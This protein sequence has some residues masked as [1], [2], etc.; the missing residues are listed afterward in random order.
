MQKKNLFSIIIILC[1]SVAFAQKDGDHKRRF[2]LNYFLKNFYDISS[3]PEY[4][5]NTYNAEVSTY[6]RKGGNDDGFNGTYSFIRRNADSSLVI[7][8]QQGPG[9]ITRFWTPTPTDDTLDFYIDD[10]TKPTFSIKYR[11][12]FTGK[13]YPFVAPLCANQLGGF[14]CYLPILFNKS[15]KI[16]ARAK[17]LRFHQIGYKLYPKDYFFKSFSINLDDAEK[18]TLAQIK[19]IWSKTNL[20]AKDV[21]QSNIGIKEVKKVTTIQPGQ[22]VTLFQSSMPGRITGFEFATQSQLDTLA[23]D[24]DI[25][26]TW[27]GENAP[28][29][30][31]PIADY[32][33][34]AFGTASMNGLLVGSDGKRHYSLF[35]MPY[36]KSAKVE[37]IYRK[38]NRAGDLSAV[39]LISKFYVENRKRNPLIEGKF[40]AVW[41]HLNPVPNGQPYP[42]IDIK[43]KG[44]MVGVVL[45]SQGLISGI[46]GFFEGDDSTVIDGE[47]RFHGT[48]SEDFFNGGWYAMLDRWDDAMSLP[49]SGS[50]EYSLPLA[51]TGGYR[52]FIT[53]KFAFN[54]SLFH[55]IEHG[56]EGNRFPADY[57]SVT[58]YYCDRNNAQTVLPNSQNTIVTTLD[59]LEIYPQLTLTAMDEKLDATA[60]WQ[61]HPAKAVT[62]TVNDDTQLKYYLTDVPAGNYEVLFEYP[63]TPVSAQFS[64]WQ[65]QTEV[66]DWKDASA[67]SKEDFKV[68]KMADLSFSRLDRTLSLR[69]KTT[70]EKNKFILRRIILV[71]KK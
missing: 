16:V 9:I 53:D 38:T 14:Y 57:T 5:S 4:S 34:Y 69:F 29:V 12:L 13:V 43:G 3:L 47:L 6:D 63:K 19:K 71:R 32:F 24:I 26:I 17:M 35:P 23:K 39:T 66:M 46:T 30:Y 11:D 18:E 40:Y 68:V 67:A 65:R 45:Q 28:A 60:S 58:Y 50:L 33:G 20:T 41:N 59:T 22:T 70:A 56:P 64:L 15:C 36:D 62:Y 49:L 51:H 7:F 1:C 37:L 52:L 55:S 8:D 2:D 48:G 61:G 42:M 54:K 10:T 31:A 27:D 44:H 21:Y 25:K